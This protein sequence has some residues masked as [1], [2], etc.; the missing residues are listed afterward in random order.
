MKN[1]F[2]VESPSKSK[3]IKGYLGN[4]YE[5][6]ATVGH[7]KDLPSKEMGVD[8][9][10]KY[11]MKYVPTP[12][13]KKVISLLSSSIKNTDDLIILATDPDREGEAISWQVSELA[14]KNKKKY[15]RITF[16]EI[17]KEAIFNALKKPRDIDYNLV[18]S[19][20]SRR[21]L[22]R[23]SG[24]ELSELLWKKI[25]YGL[26]AGRVQSVAL[27][28]IMDRE[29][30]IRNF[31]P[32]KYSI[33]R[34]K[35]DGLEYFLWN[36][37]KKI[38]ILKDD[39][40]ISK[41]KEKIVNGQSVTLKSIDIK[42]KKLSPPA[43][44]NTALLQQN[45][46]RALG[47]SASRTMKVAQQLYQGIN[48]SGKGNVG[49]ITYMR[50]DSFNISEKAINNIRSYIT[51]IYGKS[52]LS[53]KPRL[54]KT[55]SKVAQEAHE[56][57]R[58]TDVFI[59][60]SDIKSSLTDEQYKIYKLI[61]DRVV[62]TQMSEMIVES[63]TPIWNTD[64]ILFGNNFERITFE[65][66]GKVLTGYLN[67]YRSIPNIDDLKELKVGMNSKYEDVKFEEKETHPKSRY[68]EATLI[69]KLEASGVGRPSTYASIISTIILRG[70][71]EIKEKKLFPTDNG[72]V[73]CKFLENYFSE[74]VDPTFTSD[75]EDKLDK[76]ANGD[77]KMIK[78][79]DDFYKPFHKKIIEGHDN[80]KKED[81]VVLEKSDEKC[82][83]CGEQML[84]KIGKNG[85]FLSCSKFPE[86]KG[87]KSIQQD[88]DA[89]KYQKLDKCEKC[90]GEMIIKTGK[91]GKFW[92]CSNYPKCKNIKPM[93]LNEK[94]P[95]CGNNLV[96]RKGKWGKS[97]T[98]CSGYPKCKYIKK[99]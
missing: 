98:G 92:S 99:R 66:F 2:I 32:V 75:M 93:F 58:P 78:V 62:S 54:Y 95:E 67:I 43:P 47:F 80:I 38:K 79:L 33:V 49:L 30:E 96:E 13:H 16:N 42:S 45:A 64:E 63:I 24:Y 89:E 68:T 19:Q 61:W 31:I 72:E 15:V 8:V 56:A 1:L 35:I 74:I 9:N 84:V 81:V 44:F 3:T 18:D 39:E 59:K 87:I 20:K 46:N 11:E 27:K 69:K 26:S 76:I 23:L 51:D 50:T 70:Y 82:P 10:N 22:D 57:I 29:R 12:K 86:C 17:T 97:F 53:E 7:I 4:D 60:P 41:L 52:Y 14:K 48:V 91:Y 6:V 85:K 71:V 5:V 73:V 28:F 88:F 83:I 37:K 90:G 65:G 77:L 21:V 55:K 34:C 94:C 25:R 40:I 36:D